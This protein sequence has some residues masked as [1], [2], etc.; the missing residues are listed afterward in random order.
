MR[1]HKYFIST[2]TP[3]TLLVLFAVCTSQALAETEWEQIDA[4]APFIDDNGHERSP[5]CS[6]GPLL[7][8]DGS[9]VPAETDYSFFIRKGNPRKLLIALD[10]GGACWDSNTCIG[11]ALVP[12]GP[13]YT[14]AV[15]ET[16][17]SLNQLGGVFNLDQPDNTFAEYT[18]VFIPYCS[19]DVHWGSKDTTYLYTTPDGAQIPWTIKHR[20]HDNVL[21]VLRWLKDYYESDLGQAP[22][23]VAVAG[24]SAGGYGALLALPAVK[25]M[26]PRRT[27]T[28]LL[29]DSSNGVVSEDFY[30][31]A[32]GGAEVKDGAWGVERNLSGSL[33]GAFSSGH[34]KLSLATI[35]SLAWRYPRTRIGQYTRAWDRVQVSYYNIT[36]ELQFPERWDDPEFLLPSAVEWTIKARLGMRLSSLAPNYRLYIGAGT[37]HTILA[38]S[39]FYSENSAQGVPFTHWVDDMI[40]KRTYW[41]T[42]K[43]SDWRN[44]SCVPDC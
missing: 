30:N 29:V 39:S 1:L 15:N 36:K 14:L 21:A 5:S 18:Q 19:A 32:I 31:R 27:R 9:V 11:S 2:F 38:D 28:H 26:L 43:N 24:A 7:G 22:K 42:H 17:E 6:G 23:E 44:V 8:A 4:S 33:L 12:G 3:L 34:D 25:K 40:N 35:T 10:G 16:A 13:L 37:D 41:W 20:G